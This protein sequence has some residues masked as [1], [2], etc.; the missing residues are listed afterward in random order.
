MAGLD[1]AIFFGGSEEDVR[2]EPGQ[3]ESRGMVTCYGGVQSFK[4][5]F[6]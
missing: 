5:F 3:D 1:P 4:G 6:P 2:D